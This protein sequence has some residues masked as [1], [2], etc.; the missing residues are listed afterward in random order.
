MD[1]LS[2]TASIIAIL[3]LTSKAIVYLE[4]VNSASK[5]HAQYTIEVSNLYALLAKSKD[6]LKERTSNEPWNAEVKSSAIRM[7][8]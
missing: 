3:Q 1:P 8:Y 4:D 5:D 2:V 6:C 7:A